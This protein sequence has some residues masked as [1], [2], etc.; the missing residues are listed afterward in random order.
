MKEWFLCV[1]AI[2]L[3]ISFVLCCIPLNQT[4]ALV[5]ITWCVPSLRGNHMSG[6]IFPDISSEK[7]RKKKKLIS[8][9]PLYKQY[10]KW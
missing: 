6:I 10:R 9:I 1:L 2:L 3:V 7:R 4:L 5:G 8:F